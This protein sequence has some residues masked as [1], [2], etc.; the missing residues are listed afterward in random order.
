[1]SKLEDLKDRVWVMW[2]RWRHRH[3][4]PEQKRERMRQAKADLLIAWDGVKEEF[5]D[6]PA[7]K[8]LIDTFTEIDA[9]LSQVV[10]E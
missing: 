9:V 7:T 8:E 5:K 3:D 1:M 10:K 6:T 2:Y 4:T